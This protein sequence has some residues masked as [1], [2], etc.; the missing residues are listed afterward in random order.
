MVIAKTTLVASLGIDSVVVEEEN[1]AVS[2]ETI[3]VPE[4]GENVTEGTIANWLIE[5]GSSVTKGQ[6][7]FELA[8]DKVDS[9]IP[10]PF[11]GTVTELLV[12]KGS[13]VAVG[14]AVAVIDTSSVS[15]DD[16]AKAANPEPSAQEPTVRSE[17]IRV[18][19]VGENVTE[20]TIANWLIEPGSSVTKGQALFELATDKVDSEIPSPFTGTVTELLVA[21]GSVVAV[22]DAVAVI[23]ATSTEAT[24]PVAKSTKAPAKKSAPAPS[25]AP[26]HQP[27]GATS[28]R[29]DAND[30]P[31]P[32]M[33]GETF[34]EEGI[35]PFSRIRSVTARVMVQ[36]TSTIPHATS[37]VEA[38]HHAVFI[39][40][41]ELKA[42]GHT[43]LPTA[44]AFATYATAQALVEFP[45]LNAS[46]KGD[47]LKLHSDIN[48]AIAV[49]TPAGLIA[50]VIH[51]A[52]TLSVGEIAAAINELAERAREGQL[53][54]ADISGATFTIS[55]NGSAGSVMTAAIITPPQVAVLSTDR[56][57]ERPV[58]VSGPEGKGI[59]IRPMGN[60]TMTWDHRAIDGAEAAHFLVSIKDHLE[61]N[62]WSRLV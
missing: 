57:V 47:G 45:H 53:S 50:P 51:H 2:D 23:E 60:L 58:V 11:T 55:N 22:G 35:E 18:P 7:L 1:D 34:E 4:V 25:T 20:G 33:P 29:R 44:L 8:T 31:L 19:D 52:N 24:T 5:P 46:V 12:A 28:Q 39:L 21:K 41:R 56:V 32:P 37:L 16:G 15:H 26:V 36:S 10:S 17:T 30:V 9:E 40:R 6:A 48:I 14:D 62:D 59:G 54:A 38:D 13:V 49:D 42:K 27:S 61:T 43:P 3:R